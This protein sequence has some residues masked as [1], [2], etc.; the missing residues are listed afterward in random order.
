MKGN[1]VYTELREQLDLKLGSKLINTVPEGIRDEWLNYAYKKNPVNILNI[2]FG[3]REAFAPYDSIW[4]RPLVTISQIETI[5]MKSCPIY[6]NT[7]KY[8]GYTLTQNR[9][10]YVWSSNANLHPFTPEEIASNPEKFDYLTPEQG[11]KKGD[12]I[13][14]VNEL[15]P[16]IEEKIY[17]YFEEFKTIED[18]Y[19]KIFPTIETSQYNGLPLYQ[20]AFAGFQF[21]KALIV[22]KEMQD[23]N[24]KEYYEWYKKTIPLGIKQQPI[25]WQ[26]HHEI[27]PEFEAN[28]L[29]K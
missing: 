16:K 28:Y 17:P 13:P 15:I 9:E 2:G 18:V 1:I 29:L 12:L 11:F 7:H 26:K 23:L 3:D 5:L 22:L 27:F 6:F 10:T 21:E 8:N 24:F 20:R 4:V 25:I 14:F 19:T